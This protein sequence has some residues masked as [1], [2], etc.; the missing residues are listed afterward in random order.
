MTLEQWLREA[1]GTFPAGVQKRL[2]QEYRAHLE[3]SLAAG[4]DGDVKNLFGQ[5]DTVRRQLEKS[6]VVSKRLADLDFT[7]DRSFWFGVAMLLGML[8]FGLTW[9]DKLQALILLTVGCTLCAS[10]WRVT[11]RWTKLRRIAFRSMYMM[12]IFT[13]L[14]IYSCFFGEQKNAIYG[15][16]SLVIGFYFIWV[17]LKQD[18][19]LR[20]T[21]ALEGQA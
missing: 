21:L 19:R 9:I 18:V 14:N 20:R 2:A 3:E 4:N 11:C 15:F 8:L 5:P 1:T 10:L 7:G 13:F 6:Y 12:I 17:L 16:Y